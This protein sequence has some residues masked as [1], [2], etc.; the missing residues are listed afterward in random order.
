MRKGP[1]SETTATYTAYIAMNDLSFM[2]KFD[3]W[4]LTGYKRP[5]AKSCADLMQLGR[6][7]A[8]D[9]PRDFSGYS[10]GCSRSLSTS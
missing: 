7:D 1:P 8:S 10:L 5:L 9:R 4:R 3:T 6:E 2:K